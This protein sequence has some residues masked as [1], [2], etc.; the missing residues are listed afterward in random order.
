MKTILIINGEKYWK[1]YFAGFDVVQKKI[2]TAEFIVKDSS[3]YVVDAEGVCKP[4]VIFWR[5]GAVNPEPKH[6]N[7][8]ELIRYSEIPC[9][10]SAETLLK[11]YDRLSMLNTLKKLGLPIINFDVATQTSQ[12]KNLQMSFPF[13]VK[14]GNHHGGFGKSLVT[15]EEQWEELKD[16]LF[17]HQDYVTVEKFIDYKYDIRYLAINDKVWAMKR[18]GKYWKANALTQEYQ[19]IEPEK[20]WTKNVKLLQENSKADIIAIDVLETENGE[21]TI[22]EYN[23]IPGLS[24]F[25]EDTK[26]ELSK[27][28]K[29]K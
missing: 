3:L 20:E 28:V 6:R 12:L 21:K 4:D 16:L 29:N 11:G 5:L 25:P 17:I 27:M 18:K 9:V 26:L 19:I 23:D 7:I 24:G 1:D 10:N 15:S 8:L 22:L 14:V 13:V 2:Q